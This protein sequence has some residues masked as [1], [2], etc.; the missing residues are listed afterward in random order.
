MSKRFSSIVMCGRGLQIG[1][2]GRRRRRMIW[3]SLSILVIVS[4]SQHILLSVLDASRIGNLRRGDNQYSIMRSLDFTRI[5]VG[6]LASLYLYF[7]HIVRASEMRQGR[8]LLSCAKDYGRSPSHWT[9]A[10]SQGVFRESVSSIIYGHNLLAVSMTLLL[11]VDTVFKLASHFSN[12]EDVTSEGDKDYVRKTCGDGLSLCRVGWEVSYFLPWCTAVMFVTMSLSIL[13][14][15][16]RCWSPVTAGAVTSTNFVRMRRFVR[17]MI[18][19]SL[20]S[21]VWTCETIFASMFWIGRGAD[22]AFVEAYAVTSVLN[23]VFE[24]LVLVWCSGGLSQRSLP[25]APVR[26]P[27]RGLS[28]T[29]RAEAPC[30]AGSFSGRWLARIRRSL[31]PHAHAGKWHWRDMFAAVCIVLFSNAELSTGIQ[32]GG[33]VGVWLLRLAV[34]ALALFFPDKTASFDDLERE[35][36]GFGLVADAPQ[37]RAAVLAAV[38]GAPLDKPLRTYKASMLRMKQTLAVSYRWQPEAVPIA[39][40]HTLNMSAW[41]M[42][43]VADAIREHRVAYVWV[44]VLSVPQTGHHVLKMTL[45]SRMMAVYASAGKTLALRSVEADGSRCGGLWTAPAEV[46]RSFSP[47]GADNRRGPESLLTPQCERKAKDVGPAETHMCIM[48]GMGGSVRGTVA[49]RGFQGEDSALYG[50]VD[51]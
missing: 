37:L 25:A 9:A 17:Y 42:K 8:Y 50:V 39:P 35:S 31:V 30:L 19:L 3:C 7:N 26:R 16:I 40:G 22:R 33:I 29:S 12:L 21:L 23:F 51:G 15:P 41:Q 27:T 28:W 44:D 38:R 1:F 43:A 5:F 48:W 46:R 6:L 45:L 34:L 11:V 13:F 32:V 14:T 47:R 10:A 20:V 4:V 24:V 49:K 36:T 18:P 2:P